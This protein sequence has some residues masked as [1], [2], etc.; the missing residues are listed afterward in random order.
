MI[1]SVLL[2]LLCSLPSLS[3]ICQPDQSDR[4]DK[5]VD[6]LLAEYAHI[7]GNVSAHCSAQQADD[8]AGDAQ[9]EVRYHQTN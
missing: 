5:G 7:V 1:K 6:K 3:L 8:T 9:D 4:Y 2:V